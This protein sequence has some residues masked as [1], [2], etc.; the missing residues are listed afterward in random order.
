MR[1]TFALAARLDLIAIGDYI[2]QDSPARADSFVEE[3]MA[4]CWRLVEAPEAY[5]VVY[6]RR[7]IRRRP[8]G[9]YN[10]FYVCRAEDVLI[11]HVLNAAQDAGRIL[12]R[13]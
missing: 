8:F 13:N 6:P 9:A 7:N 1:L 12:R 2:A 5:P 11:L 3:L 4:C 10:I